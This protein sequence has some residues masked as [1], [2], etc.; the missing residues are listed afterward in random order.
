MQRYRND[1]IDWDDYSTSTGNLEIENEA[2]SL[3]RDIIIQFAGD[4][5]N[6]LVEA[7][8][9]V[10]HRAAA[11][12]LNLGCPQKIAKRGH[13]GAYLLHD[14][15]LV[16]KLL[17]AMVQRL[18]CPITA[19]IRVLEDDEATLRLCRKME[20]CGIQMLTVHGRTV[21]SSKLF[22]G[23]ADWDII[24]KIK[25]EVGIPV[26][27]N[28]GISCR[29]DALRCLKE[30]GADGVMSSEGLLENPKLFSEEGDRLFRTDYIR[31]QMQTVDDYMET[32]KLHCPQKQRVSKQDE[33]VDSINVEVSLAY[34]LSQELVFAVTVMKHI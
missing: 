32:V 25:N 9:Y 19:K 6:I 27:A 11:I 5:P 18:D 33:S 21:D 3:D 14:S 4:D 7:G 34:V 2:K 31:A 13:Y 16:V 1:C 17:T 23:P 15:E 29:E 8:K 22:T 12:D 24:K 10:H 28:G 30:T 20:K 26:V